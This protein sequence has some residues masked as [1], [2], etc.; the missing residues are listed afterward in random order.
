MMINIERWNEQYFCHNVEAPTS[1][2]HPFAM[3]CDFVIGPS[4]GAENIAV[5]QTVTAKEGF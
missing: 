4:A 1:T 5:I 3:K 2:P